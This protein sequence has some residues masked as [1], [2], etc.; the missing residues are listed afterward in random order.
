MGWKTGSMHAVT[1]LDEIYE[2]I[3]GCEEAHHNNHTTIGWVPPS[4]FERTTF[5]FWVHDDRKESASLQKA[6]SM[7]EDD[8]EDKVTRT[9]SSS[10]GGST[11]S[12]SSSKLRPKHFTFSECYPNLH[13]DDAA[14]SS[15]D[16][17]FFQERFG[18]DVPGGGY[19]VW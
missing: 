11:F 15:D 3:H 18:G 16:K 13:H 10:S 12:N 14:S 9:S 5:K 8:D 4:T 19:S 2:M 7:D 17:T 1:L 6:D